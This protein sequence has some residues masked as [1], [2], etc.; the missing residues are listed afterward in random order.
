MNCPKCFSYVSGSFCKTCDTVI[1]E[2]PVKSKAI[3]KVSDKTKAKNLIYKELREKF[4]S[5]NPMCQ[6]FPHLRA[7]DVHHTKFRGK[8][9]L[10]VSTFMAV[11]REA[12]IKIHKESK[13][14]LS[15]GYIESKNSTK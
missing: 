13:W 11:S 14:A 12:H 2:K 15:M 6:V 10:D 9:Y 3:K 8:N 5:E 7:T 1:F 4:L